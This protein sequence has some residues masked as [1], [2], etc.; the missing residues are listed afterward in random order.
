MSWESTC[1]SR[2]QLCWNQCGDGRCE[3]SNPP[4]QT[5]E[6]VPPPLLTPGAEGGERWGLEADPLTRCDS[7]FTDAPGDDSKAVST[8]CV[9]MTGGDGEECNAESRACFRSWTMRASYLSMTDVRSSSQWRNL[10]DG[11]TSRNAKNMQAVK[12]LVLGRKP[13]VLG[14]LWQTSRT[15]SCG[16]FLRQRLGGMHEDVTVDFVFARDAGR[17]SR[18][19]VSNN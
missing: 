4:E 1:W 2:R 17:A 10:R 13:E 7:G 3:G 18:C 6:N 19:L 11:C 12:R 16:R 9:L 8:P 15:A 14:C 5:A